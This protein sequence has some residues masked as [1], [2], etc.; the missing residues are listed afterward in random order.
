MLTFHLLDENPLTAVREQTWKETNRLIAL[1]TEGCK[2]TT[3]W[4]GSRNEH[5]EIVGFF[6]IFFA[7]IIALAHYQF[8][9][10]QR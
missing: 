5:M 10:R 6:I 8:G 7:L 9:N 4:L 3:V 2:V 1:A